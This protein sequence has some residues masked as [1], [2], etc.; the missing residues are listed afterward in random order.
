MASKARSQV[1]REHFIKKLTDGDF[2]SLYGT[3]EQVLETYIDPQNDLQLKAFKHLAATIFLV[4]SP[5]RRDTLL[6]LAAA[7]LSRER[8]PALGVS[9]QWSALETCDERSALESILPFLGSLLSGSTF[10]SN[11]VP[12]LP[13]HTSFRD[14]LVE[15]PDSGVFSVDIGLR[16]QE[17]LA[18][19]C[20][21]I[22][23]VQLKFNMCNFDTSYALNSEIVDLHQRVEKIFPELKYACQSAAYHIGIRP[24][25]AN[26][27]QRPLT[28]VQYRLEGGGPLRTF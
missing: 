22:M 16:H 9:E 11:Q 7:T 10:D 5:Q 27:P 4:R 23:N 12:V 6:P 19:A 24:E 8:E 18:L 28:E 26:I 21:D 2:N 14:F 15:S 25:E 20:L 3:Y 13:L 1:D 17:L